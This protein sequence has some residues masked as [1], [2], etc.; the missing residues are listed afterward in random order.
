MFNSIELLLPTY[1]WRYFRLNRKRYG[2]FDPQ[3][4]TVT[5]S[6]NRRF[7]MSFTTNGTYSCIAMERLR[8]KGSMTTVKIKKR[9]KKT[10]SDVAVENESYAG[11]LGVDPGVVNYV[12]ACYVPKIG[13]KSLERNFVR[14]SA[15]FKQEEC[16]ERMVRRR[17]DRVVG[18][19][20]RE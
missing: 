1:W 16:K 3:T 18:S 11:Y 20:E 9:T 14:R 17:R 6:R 10:S 19:Y 12:G 7:A 8:P 15:R 4:N 5:A 2:E 13:N